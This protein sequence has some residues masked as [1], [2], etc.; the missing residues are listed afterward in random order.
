MAS[1]P[2]VPPL[3]RHV[4]LT[5]EARRTAAAELARRYGQGASIR[6]LSADTRY[7][8]GRVRRL[9]LDAG[10]T[11]RSRGGNHTPRTN[12]SARQSRT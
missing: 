10:V 5:G 6:N 7:S 4:R 2:T 3:E 8:I 12:T 9:L 11:F 1:S